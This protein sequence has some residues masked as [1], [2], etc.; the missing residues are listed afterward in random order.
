M[1]AQLNPT[2]V[3]LAFMMISTTIVTADFMPFDYRQGFYY[4]C[5]FYIQNGTECSLSSTCCPMLQMIS[6][7]VKSNNTQDEQSYACLSMKAALYDMP[8]YS[9]NNTRDMVQACSLTLPFDVS[10]G[11]SCYPSSS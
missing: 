2:Y 1:A 7:K 8:N 3:V 11:A 6:N 4:A 10:R 5:K 9:Y